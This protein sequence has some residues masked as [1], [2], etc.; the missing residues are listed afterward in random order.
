MQKTSEKK[1]AVSGPLSFRFKKDPIFKSGLHVVSWVR[2]SGFLC[3]SVCLEE[4]DLGGFL[5][6][7]A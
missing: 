3:E 2:R 6:G 5:E 4:L 7:M 1:A